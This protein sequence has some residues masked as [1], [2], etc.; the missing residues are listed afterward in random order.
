MY[1]K[2][3]FRIDLILCS[4]MCSDGFQVSLAQVLCIPSAINKV[5]S[6]MREAEQIQVLFA[7]LSISLFIPIWSR[8]QFSADTWLRER[9][10]WPWLALTHVTA[11]R[12][13]QHVLV[14][15]EWSSYTSTHLH[16]LLILESPFAHDDVFNAP[17]VTKLLLKDGVIFKEF[18]GLLLWNSIQG[19]LVDDS[20]PLK[21][22]RDGKD[23]LLEH[24]ISILVTTWKVI[25]T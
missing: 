14:T 15:A 11:V 16:F 21:L 23:Y 8:C 3:F 4:K 6:T 22:R 2:G 19:V 7:C 12:T 18:L 9:S 17:P 20:Y 1:I 10:L 5:P 25:R 13:G 24:S